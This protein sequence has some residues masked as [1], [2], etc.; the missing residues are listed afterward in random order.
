MKF[1][2]ILSVILLVAIVLSVFCT[3]ASAATVNFKPV[4]QSGYLC[5]TALKTPQN[6]F[7]ELFGSRDLKIYSKGQEVAADSNVKI[8][9]G[10]T[11]KLD[12]RV[13]YNV[14]VMGDVTGDGEL[15]SMD[16]ILVKRTV[17]G[18][19]Q[20]TPTQLRAAE[21]APGE[22]I[23]AINYIKVKRAYFDTYDIN[24]AY[25]CEPYETT[26]PPSDDGWSDGWV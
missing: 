23:R 8:G 5:G 9:T 26:A 19:Y 16:Y 7:R 24:S 20:L 2:K 13:F 15:T 10:F 18:S 11:I 1:S 4:I 21:V 25:T 14:V 17:L 6:V 12:N 22:E 3:P